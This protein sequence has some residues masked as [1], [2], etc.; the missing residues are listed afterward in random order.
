MEINRTDVC[1]ITNAHLILTCLGISLLNYSTST[2]ENNACLTLSGLRN[3]I[4]TWRWHLATRHA[5]FFVQ[6]LWNINAEKFSIDNLISFVFK[7]FFLI[8]YIEILMNFFN[9]YFE[10]KLNFICLVSFA[11][12]ISQK[13]LN[14]AKNTL[15]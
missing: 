7:I 1:T 14:K 11:R 12:N 4:F 15:K 10:K 6:L 3:F 5:S 9:V 13:L 2:K 8:F